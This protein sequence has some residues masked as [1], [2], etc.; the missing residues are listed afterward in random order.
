MGWRS[1]LWHLWKGHPTA[2]RWAYRSVVGFVVLFTIAEV[3]GLL[4]MHRLSFGFAVAAVVFVKLFVVAVI[5][6]LVTSWVQYARKGRG[7][8][9]ETGPTDR[10][11]G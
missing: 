2:K 9:D 11:R 8:H 3:F 7:K 5:V 6:D 1:D 4:E 10:G